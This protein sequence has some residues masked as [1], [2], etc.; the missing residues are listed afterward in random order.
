M[1]LRIKFNKR[2]GEIVLNKVAEKM[3][4]IGE[5]VAVNAKGSM[6][7]MPFPS[8]PRQTTTN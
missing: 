3:Q 6:R 2:A 5:E 8:Q 4:V 7:R 1:P